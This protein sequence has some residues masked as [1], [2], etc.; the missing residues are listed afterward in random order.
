[1]SVVVQICREGSQSTALHTHKEQINNVDDGKQN[2]EW[3]VR[4]VRHI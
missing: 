4:Q 3:E 2:S 1:M